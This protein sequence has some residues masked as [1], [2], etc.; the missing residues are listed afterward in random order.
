MESLLADRKPNDS[1]SIDSHT[2]IQIYD[3]TANNVV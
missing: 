3:S 2:V 1:N